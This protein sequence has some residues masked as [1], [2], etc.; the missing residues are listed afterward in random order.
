VWIVYLSGW[1]GMLVAR[2]DAIGIELCVLE[3]PAE[4]ARVSSAGRS[5]CA[6]CVGAPGRSN[7]ARVSRFVGSFGVWQLRCCVV[8]RWRRGRQRER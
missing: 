7:A 5:D 6:T 3:E 1:K 8:S 2:L 4:T